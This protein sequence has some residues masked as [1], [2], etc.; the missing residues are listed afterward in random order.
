MFPVIYEAGPISIHTLWV[1]VAIAS[2]V[3]SYLAVTRLKR[4]RVNLNLFINHSTSYLISALFFSRV[5]YFFLNTDAYFPAIDLRTLINFISIW[6][7]GF[8]FWGALFGLTLMLIYRLHKAKEDIWKWFDALSVPL[9]VGMIIGYLGAFLGGYAY[10]RPTNLPWGIKY[11][12]INVK[13]TVAVH[14][15][16]IYAILL[17]GFILWSKKKLKEKTTFF[18]VSGNTTL[19]I[20]STLSLGL[21]LLEFLRGDDT[22]IIL[23]ARLPQILYPLIFIVST[24]FLIRRIINFKKEKHE[25][26]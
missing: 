17:L 21:F 24:V 22:L 5:T 2:L 4:R 14:P 7:Q 26:A 3:A 11:E 10:G 9:L 1:F 25:S 12:V 8:S 18:E 15:T 13:Y 19:Y 6:D 20:T 23:G 16:Q